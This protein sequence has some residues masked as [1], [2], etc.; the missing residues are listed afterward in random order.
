IPVA[1]PE[2][3]R[4][5]QPNRWARVQQRI[6]SNRA[7]S[8]RNSKHQYL[9]SGL[10]R[11]GGCGSIYV[12]NPSHGQFQYR[13]SKRCRRIPLISEG[14]LNT[15]VWDAVEAALRDPAILTKA[16]TNIERPTPTSDRE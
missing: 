2:S 7:F 9:L 5:V 1:M 10:V 15:S 16:I 3:L 13:C 14:I 8:P 4:L 11:C 6:D 12:G